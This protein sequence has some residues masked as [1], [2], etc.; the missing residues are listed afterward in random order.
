MK[1]EKFSLKDALF[2]EKKVTYLANLLEKNIK[3]FQKDNFI[4]EVCD[5]F[6]K[7]ELKERIN[8]IAFI[9]E[10]YLPKSFEEAS[11]VII[12]SLPKELDP[13][14]TDNDF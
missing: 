3:N 5:D 10:K 13:N 9:L 7:L 6:P 11:N 8:H 2:N 4:K 14:N 12:N 1:K